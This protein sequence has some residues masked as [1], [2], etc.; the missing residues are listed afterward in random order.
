MPLATLYICDF[1]FAETQWPIKWSKLSP[2][3]Y[4]SQAPNPPV[5]IICQS[6]KTFLLENRVKERAKK[7]A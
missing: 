4:D 1:C 5:E 7:L 3:K 2:A 6:C